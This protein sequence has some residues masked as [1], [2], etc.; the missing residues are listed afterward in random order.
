MLQLQLRCAF[1][2][3]NSW[4]NLMMVVL[5]SCHAS[6]MNVLWIISD[7]H[8]RVCKRILL[9]EVSGVGAK[10]HRCRDLTRA[11]VRQ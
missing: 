6:M 10:R 9:P 5:F 8:Y 11:P 4:L 1:S 2:S 3:L 7:A